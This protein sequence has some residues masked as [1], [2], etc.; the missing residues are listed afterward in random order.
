MVIANVPFTYPPDDI[1]GI[2]YSGLM[3]PG[4]DAEFATPREVREEI[5]RLIPDYQI[6]VDE[7]LTLYSMNK[8]V[9]LM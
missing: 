7:K 6:N 8:N 3:T 9:L 2:M 1:N 4:T 5:L